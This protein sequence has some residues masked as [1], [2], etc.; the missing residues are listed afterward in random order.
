[1][2]K[3]Q[4]IHKW[5][6][7]LH[8]LKKID[9]FVQKGEKIVICGPSGCGKSTLIRCINGLEP[10]Q[11]GTIEI[12]GIVLKDNQKSLSEIRRYIGM[13]VSTI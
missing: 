1:M 4:N 11:A 5:Y 2:I 12:N 6:G 13:V 8:V 7:K 3:L 10:Y 9:L